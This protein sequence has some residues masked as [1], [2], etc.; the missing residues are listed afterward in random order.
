MYYLVFAL[1]MVTPLAMLVI[2]LYWKVHPPKLEGSGLAYR[3]S[4]ST[5]NEETWNF[6]H[7]HVAKL[8]IR[9]GFLLSLL[10][11][12]LMTLFRESYFNYFLWVIGGQMVFLCISAFLVEGMLK[13]AFDQD[14]KPLTK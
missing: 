14:G 6:A 5:R 9:I 7:R 12:L 2:G 3:T 10:S 13:S 8:W 4:L 1:V 11:I